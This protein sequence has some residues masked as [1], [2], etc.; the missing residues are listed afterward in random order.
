[1]YVDYINVCIRA[2]ETAI[3]KTL[4]ANSYLGIHTIYKFSTMLNYVNA[5][6]NFTANFAPF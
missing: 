6:I 1:M 5:S 4:Q 3:N 2:L